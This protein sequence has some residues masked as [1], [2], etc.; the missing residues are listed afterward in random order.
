MSDEKGQHLFDI[1]NTIC[2]KHIE[3]RAYEKGDSFGIDVAWYT[4]DGK[5]SRGLNSLEKTFAYGS[6]V[7]HNKKKNKTYLSISALK[8]R[9]IEIRKNEKGEI[10][11]LATIDGKP[12]ILKRIW[13][14]ASDG[15][16]RIPKVH[17]ID[18]FGIEISSGNEVKERIHK[19]NSKDNAENSEIAV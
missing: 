2:A 11:P 8:S 5:R 6:R 4:K 13:V 14:E 10:Q 1:A 19:K 12:A 7:T 18:A 9:K 3:Y 17:Y 15:H 16:L